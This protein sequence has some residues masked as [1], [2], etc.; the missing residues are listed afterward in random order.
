MYVTTN[1]KEQISGATF[2]LFMLT[3]VLLFP[4]MLLEISRIFTRRNRI[5]SNFSNPANG[6]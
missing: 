6:H 4:A 2:G 3:I 1:W 5:N